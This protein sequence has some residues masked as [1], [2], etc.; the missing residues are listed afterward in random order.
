MKK[1][2]SGEMRLETKSFYADI[3]LTATCPRCRQR[4]TI[5]M[6]DGEIEYPGEGDKDLWFLCKPCDIGLVA[7]GTITAVATI[8]TDLDVFRVEG[9]RS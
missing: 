4:L 9:D 3:D 1:K 5:S 7:T 8:E 2:Y 6:K